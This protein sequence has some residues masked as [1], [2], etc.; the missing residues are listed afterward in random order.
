MK[1][2]RGCERVGKRLVVKKGRGCESGIESCCRCRVAAMRL[3]VV[4]WFSGEL[5][6][7]VTVKERGA[8]GGG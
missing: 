2:G 1:E 8:V 7:R 3:P 6:K 4:V 5:G